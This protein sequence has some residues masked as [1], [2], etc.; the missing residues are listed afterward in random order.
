MKLY[1][2]LISADGKCFLTYFPPRICRRRMPKDGEAGR[3]KN[4]F[5][6]NQTI[7]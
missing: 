7:G 6:H 3:E 2:P 1:V 5:T 4:S